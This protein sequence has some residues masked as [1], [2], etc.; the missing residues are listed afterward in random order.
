MAQD[1]S[2]AQG[3]PK[4]IEVVA[5]SVEAGIEAGA[6]AMGVSSDRVGHEV[7]EETKPKLGI[8][9]A[10]VKVR[11]HLKPPEPRVHGKFL[12]GYRNERFYLI[13]TPPSGRGRSI[14]AEQLENALSG[15]P[16]PEGAEA[17]W[18]AELAKPTGEAIVLTGGGSVGATRTV[19]AA[20]LLR[21]DSADSGAAERGEAGEAAEEGDGSESDAAPEYEGPSFT[22]LVSEDQMRA[23]LLNS[24]LEF[25][26]VLPREEVDADLVALGVTFGISEILLER[27][28]TRP[29]VVPWQ[30]AQGVALVDGDNGSIEYKFKTHL[31]L[32]R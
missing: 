10:K 1:T 23:W 18:H 21:E 13:V 11:V 17:V 27:A 9:S 8:G 7:L 3:K 24:S 29:L 20:E 6:R 12:V 4:I 2:K 26:T 22:I 16:L 28:L 14:D 19:A 32:N 15:L 31:G 5:P 25:D 30:I